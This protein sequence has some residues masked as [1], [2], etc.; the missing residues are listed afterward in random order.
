MYTV[1]ITRVVRIVHAV[2]VYNMFYY[3]H[4]SR[5]VLGGCLFFV[6]SNRPEKNVAET[7]RFRLEL[8]FVTL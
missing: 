1:C 6:F 4:S 7:R 8:S 3:Y 2:Y 5:R